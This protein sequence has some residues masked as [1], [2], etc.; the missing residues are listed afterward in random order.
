MAITLDTITLPD[1]VFQ[2][3]FGAPP[4]AAAVE[5]SIINTPIVFEA[6]RPTGHD[7]TLYGGADW[8]WITHSVLVA[9]FA[10]ASIAGARYQ[11]NYEGTL[12]RVRFMPETGQVISADPLHPRPNAEATDYYNNVVIPLMEV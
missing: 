5:T 7:R 8:G 4:V 1:L 11:L 6:E 2:N 9:L 12:Y 10:L 3:P